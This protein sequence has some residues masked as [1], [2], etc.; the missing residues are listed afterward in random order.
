MSPAQFQRYLNQMSPNELIAL[1][2][3]WD[4]FARPDQRPPSGNWLIWLL[5]GGRG[6][7]KTRA[8][9]EW[10]RARVNA[11]ASRIALVAPSLGE[12]REVMF[13]GE[14]GL[15]N[16]GFPSERPKLISSRHRLEWPNGAIGQIFSSEDPDGLRGPQFDLSLI[17]I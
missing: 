17:H 4:L 7:G 16:I 6:S 11:G 3:N 5:L 8:G 9:A 2:H 12:A 1:L 14:S 10:V 15:S 13:E